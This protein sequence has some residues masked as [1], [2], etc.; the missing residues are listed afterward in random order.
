MTFVPVVFELGVAMVPRL[1]PHGLGKVPRLAITRM[2]LPSVHSQ[3]GSAT[4]AQRLI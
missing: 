3:Q 4:Q 1:W 2:E